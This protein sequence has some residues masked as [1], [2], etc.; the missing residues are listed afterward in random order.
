MTDAHI[1]LPGDL[2]GWV[3]ILRQ[4]RTK[5]AELDQVEAAAREKIQD[6]LGDQTEGRIDGKPV[7]RWTHT[8]PAR[9]LDKKA[10]TADHPDLVEKYTVI[11]EPGR[12]FTLLDPEDGA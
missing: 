9:R 6:A 8:A 7:V 11:G 12:R 10:L 2:A 5:R 4:C 3:A 1:D